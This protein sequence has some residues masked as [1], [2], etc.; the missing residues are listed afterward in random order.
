MI[1][2]RLANLLSAGRIYIDHTKQYVNRILTEE[3]GGEFD[4]SAAFSRQY[5]SRFGYRCMEALRNHVLHRGFVV[6]NTRFE[7]QWINRG[8]RKLMLFA[9]SPYL[10]PGQLRE[11]KEFKKTVLDEME[12]KGDEIDFKALVRDYVEG[13]SE[14]HSEINQHLHNLTREWEGVLRDSIARF[15]SD[16]PDESIIGP[17]AVKR[18]A[19]G[20]YADEVPNF[21]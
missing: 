7:H 9:I 6:H 5:D 11:N 18:D 16:Y 4:V 19:N 1:D 12:A 2:R 17:A 10:N 8:K 14:I 13:L 20:L 15:Q 3:A 21:H